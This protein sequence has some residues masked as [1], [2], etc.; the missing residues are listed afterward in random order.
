MDGNLREKTNSKFHFIVTIQL[1]V[2][3]PTQDALGTSLCSTE[4][5]RVPKYN[6]PRYEQHNFLFE[7]YGYI[8]TMVTVIIYYR[9]DPKSGFGSG[10]HRMHRDAWLIH[11]SSVSHDISF[12]I[13]N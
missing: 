2:N 9:F 4:G 3:S 12:K 11:K 7:N 8:I 13:Q 5:K 10:A 6:L 1:K